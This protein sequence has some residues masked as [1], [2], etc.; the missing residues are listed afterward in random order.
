[1]ATTG[2]KKR[3]ISIR[4]QL[5]LILLGL[6]IA[7][8]ISSTFLQYETQKEFLQRELAARETYIRDGLT[9]KANVLLNNLARQTEESIASFDFFGIT[10][11]LQEAVNGESELKLDYAILM[12]ASR[13]A[14]VHTKSPKLQNT[15]LDTEEDQ[16]ASAV[17]DQTV[18]EYKINGTPVMEFMVPLQISTE[19]WGVLRLGVSLEELQQ[20]I[21]RSEQEIDR[22]IN[23]M[24][25]KFILNGIALIAIGA[26]IIVLI[27]NKLTR[28]IISLTESA[29]ELSKGN[30]D[31]DVAVDER[32]KNEVDILADS[33]RSMVLSIRQ[34]QA[35]LKNL[36]QTLEQKVID[37]TR[38][39]ASKEEA[40]RVAKEEAEQANRAKSSFLANMSHEIR[41]P[42]NAVLG[43]AEIMQGNSH[44]PEQFR[45]SVDAISRAGNHLLDVINE[46]LDISKIEAGA[47]ELN[48]Q[49]FDLRDL[50]LGLSEMFAI[51]CKQGGLDWHIDQNL[52]NPT[53]VHADQG[54]IRQ[55]L[56]NFL[57][58]AV[59]F[60]DSGSVTMTVEQVGENY[61]FDIVDTGRGIP[62]SQLE[63]IYEP[64]QQSTEGFNKGGTGL[65]LSIA[66][67]YIELMGGELQTESVI[68]QGSRF[69]FTLELQPAHGPVAERKDRSSHEI[70]LPENAIVNALVVDD[71]EDNRVVL[72][73]ILKGVGISVETATNGQEALD[74]IDTHPVDI[75]FMD[76]R[77]PVL[78]GMEAIKTLRAGKHSDLV[79]IAVSAS[80]LHKEREHC[81]TAGFNE[82]IAKP[83][84]AEQIFQCVESFLEIKFVEA[85]AIEQPPQPIEDSQDFSGLVIPEDIHQRLTEAAELNAMMRIESLINE[86]EALDPEFKSLAKQISVLNDSY[87]MDGIGAILEQISHG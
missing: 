43:Y 42:M 12:D 26:I 22:E 29:R 68:G 72:S 31:V 37:R 3:F 4:V 86:L 39:L 27:A 36:N 53:N 33:F 40:L 49:D 80:T 62:A 64:F 61:R 69:S 15:I 35:A 21:A 67:K 70:H 16:F 13:M 57:G 9:D 66:K 28:P 2:A 58:N 38:E 82:F 74:Y 54:K 1:M 79:C 44:F 10:Q 7:L 47:V 65:G 85:E 63:K 19:P 55:V 76:I 77:M 34:S 11:N 52:P 20:E 81:V 51:R 73:E 17:N 75:V 50:V 24:I 5:L 59:K 71:I 87:D 6:L 46:I 45:P 84:R 14:Y 30:Y 8:Q 83:F 78:D 41:T 32:K 25:V 56:I 18:V 48:H 23:T 60:T